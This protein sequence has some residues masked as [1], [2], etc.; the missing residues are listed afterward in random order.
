MTIPEWTRG[1][2][3]IPATV[4][5]EIER[6]GKAA[7]ARDEEACGYLE[8]PATEPL[9]I[10]RAVEL[11]NLAN[12]Y[13]EVDPEG[14]PRTGREYFK[15]NSKK[16]E[17]AISEGS[18]CGRP[19]KVF[20]P[21]APRLRRV[22]Q[23]RGCREHDARRQRR[24]HLR[25]RVPRDGGGPG[26]G[27]RASLV[28]VGRA[29]AGFRRSPVRASL[30]RVRRAR[31]FVA[32]AVLLALGLGA[33]PARADLG[34]DVDALTLAWSA[35]GRVTHLAPRLLERGDVLPL[36]LPVAPLDP[37]TPDCATLAVLGVSSMQ[38]LLDAGAR[39]RATSADWPE[40]SLAGALEVTRCGET[41]SALAALA[42]EMRS[43][44]GV[45]EFLVLESDE[46]PPPVTVVLPERDA[47]TLP[48]PSSSGPRPLV[49]PVAVR[50]HSLE[51]RAAR[52]QAIELT[53][54]Q[55]VAGGGGTGAS[56]LTLTPG[57]HRFALLAE[58]TERRGADVDLEISK[59]DGNEVLAAD[60]GESSDGG[61]LLCVAVPTTINVRFGGVAAFAKLALVRARWDLDRALPARWPNDVR[62][63]MSGLLRGQRR[64]LEAAPP[65]G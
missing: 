33:P 31:V 57:C 3:K 46:P 6:A 60:H 44:R 59:A 14:H 41:K 37:K 26:R 32:L 2:V 61:A 43:P 36:E 52:E 50:V 4:L 53:T 17:R 22:F 48:Q 10:D 28:R 13:H 39:T 8:G 62:A 27:E 40:G 9:V 64:A 42:L 15:I 54:V 35:F 49:A 55:L 51:E 30:N 12:K 16:F 56:L 18:S 45:L 11:E 58:E 65:R 7:Y 25:S 23:R 19:V 5:S 34:R 20:F 29:R 21:L 47:G 38:F 24:P 63:R 1:G